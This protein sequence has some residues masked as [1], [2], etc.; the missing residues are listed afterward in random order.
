MAQTQAQQAIKKEEIPKKKPQ[1]IQPWVARSAQT[2]SPRVSQEI[3][4]V[5][6]GEIEM[7]DIEEN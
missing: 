2:L 4:E 3:L 6:M 5:I 7:F 1:T